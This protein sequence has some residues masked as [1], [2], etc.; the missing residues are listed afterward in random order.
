[1]KFDHLDK[2]KDLAHPPKVLFNSGLMLGFLAT[3]NT[4]GLKAHDPPVAIPVAINP[5][6][7]KTPTD[8]PIPIL[9][10]QV[11]LRR[12]HRR[13]P[14][15][16]YLDI[17]KVQLGDVERPTPSAAEFIRL[18]FQRPIGTDAKVII[19][20]Q[21][22]D[23]GDVIGKLGLTPIQLQP[24]NLF[25]SIIPVRKPGVRLTRKPAGQ[26]EDK[27]QSADRG[28]QPTML[29]MSVHKRIGC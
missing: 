27:G 4:A 1:M 24:F 16:P 10:H 26:Y 13:I 23:H 22:I 5:G 25:M 2:T 3:G 8:I 17:A 20:Q 21:P 19:G 9:A 28:K 7:P 15:N 12:N 6:I 11:S 18:G 14:V 29:G